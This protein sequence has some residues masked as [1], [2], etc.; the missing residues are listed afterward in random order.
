MKRNKSDYYAKEIIITGLLVAMDLVLNRFLS[1]KT[2]SLSIGFDF[3]PMIVAAMLFGP[4][5]AAVVHGLADFMGA[6]LFPVGPYFPGFTLSVVLMGLVCGF[7]L[8]NKERSLW[9]AVLAVAICQYVIAL[10]LTTFWIHILYGSPYW[11]TMLTRLVQII[12]VSVVQV[13]VIPLL[14]QLVKQLRRL[15]PSLMQET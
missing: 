1:I 10:F 3:V 13:V 14:G 15:D 9:R 6:I 11:P 5:S 4:V 12:P 2:E 7:L 8:H